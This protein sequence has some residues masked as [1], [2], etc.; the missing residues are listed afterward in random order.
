MRKKKTKTKSRRQVVKEKDTNYGKID[1]SKLSSPTREKPE[2][3]HVNKYQVNEYIV[4]SIIDKIITLS[5]RESYNNKLDKMNKNYFSDYLFKQ[6]NSLFA[7]N[8]IYYYEEPETK[9]RDDLFWNNNFNKENTW[10]E[11]T[12]PNSSKVDRYA[13]VFMKY[14]NYIPPPSPKYEKKNSDVKRSHTFKKENFIP[15]NEK[16][17]IDGKMVGKYA[18][19]YSVKLNNI[20]IKENGVMDILEENSSCSAEE[21]IKEKN[22]KKIKRT[23]K[24]NEI[25][26]NSLRSST[27]KSFTLKKSYSKN[28]LS[29]SVSPKKEFNSDYSSD[30]DENL[31]LNKKSKKQ[32]ILP[33]KYKDIP[34]SEGDF[35]LEKYSPPGVDN[36]RKQFEEEK[37]K[38][39]KESKKKAYLKKATINENNF[40]DNL[41]IIDSDKLTFDSNGKI[42]N[43][44]PI[45][46][47]ELSR[48][49]LSLKNGIKSK[50][51]NQKSPRFKRKKNNIN[52]NSRESIKIIRGKDK[53]KEKEKKAIIKNPE[54]D[55]D[56]KN[57]HNFVKI[58]SVK[59]QQIIPS[60]SSFPIMLPNIGVIVREDDQVKKGSREFGKYFQK[61]SLY[62]YD[63]IL[64]DYLPLQNKAA[65]KNNIMN[66]NNSLNPMNLTSVRKK[67][68]KSFA[69][70][71][72][73]SYKYTSTNPIVN[74]NNNSSISN[75]LPLT[76]TQN[77][78]SVNELTNPLISPQEAIQQ[79][80]ISNN[81]NN[82][83]MN[84]NSSSFIK[85]NKSNISY[86]YSGNNLY[87]MSRMNNASNYSEAGIIRL[88]RNCSSSSLKNEIENMKDLDKES[89]VNFYPTK[90]KL[91]TR[92][93][94][95]NNYQEFIKNKR[96]KKENN[97]IIGKRINELN[98]RIITKV[99][100]WGTQTQTLQKN[101]STGNLLFSKHLTKY[102]A[103]RELGSNILS[104]IKIKLPRVRKVDLN[105]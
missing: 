53:E 47:E 96:S 72:N 55:P 104:G 48:D 12:E 90:E 78:N 38:K 16:E 92:N 10:I 101:N 69:I 8:Y 9:K 89:F 34:E 73:T 46:L 85:M 7:A 95:Q 91:K 100:G 99:G 21:E 22:K 35:N 84:N 44:K 20:L 80:D 14:K 50:N 82:T 27:R 33:L 74:N 36:L 13:N 66:S 29:K 19:K 40:T 70:N 39:E 52:N 58:A 1:I 86:A 87:S 71:T 11:I 17:L 102:Q 6:L 63:K 68:P 105:I 45:R 15:G 57:S 51:S 24:S 42:I 3:I 94:F 76:Q 25:H 62:D 56:G 103:L 5:V 83:N 81:N 4:K 37:I 23:S 61:Y 75:N 79:N 59:N 49:F 77:F 65:L 18:K 26:V 98:K 30:I 41:K 67:I 43:F 54:D 93:I 88:N 2:L 60:G 97:I 32:P 28:N 64:K 31:L